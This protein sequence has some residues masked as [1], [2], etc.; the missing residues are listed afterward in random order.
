MKHRPAKFTVDNSGPTGQTMFD[1]MNRKY[2]INDSEE[3]QDEK[4]EGTLQQSIERMLGR[5]SNGKKSLWLVIM[6]AVVMRAL[7]S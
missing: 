2:R 5:D 4:K 3:D 7:V 6:F 1:P